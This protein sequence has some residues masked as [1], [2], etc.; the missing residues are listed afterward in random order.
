MGKTFKKFGG[1]NV[2]LLVV[3]DKN[4]LVTHKVENFHDG[5][6]IELIEH[7]KSTLD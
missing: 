6:E 7:L 4:G 3:V 2:P 5:Y 1:N